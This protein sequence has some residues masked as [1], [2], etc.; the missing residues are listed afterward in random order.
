MVPRLR[1]DN[2]SRGW[3]GS[4]LGGGPALLGG[5]HCQVSSA[6]GDGGHVRQSRGP[7]PPQLC[8]P[9]EKT[10][11]NHPGKVSVKEGA[12]REIADLSAG[13]DLRQTT[14]AAFVIFF[15][16]LLTL[17]FFFL[18]LRRRGPFTRR[19]LRKHSRANPEA[20][21][22]GRRLISDRALRLPNVVVIGG[23]SPGG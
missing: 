1:Q 17:L 13:D 7:R 10:P 8:F 6:E 4:R 23:D 9:R 5:V 21:N 15:F 16:P 20:G 14:V 3:R 19:S 11:T 22:V 18:L 12:V 2:E